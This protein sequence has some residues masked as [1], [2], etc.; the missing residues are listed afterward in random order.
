MVTAAHDHPVVVAARSLLKEKEDGTLY[1][2]DEG[3]ALMAFGLEKHALDATLPAAIVALY[4]LAAL[5]I[6]KGSQQPALKLLCTI[7][8][9]AHRLPVL[10]ASDEETTRSAF[11]QPVVMAAP[12]HDAEKPEGS[13]SV[14]SFRDPGMQVPLSVRRRR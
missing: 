5:L 3:A 10:T 6:E 12:S 14:A 2:D 7:Q 4:D 13:I 11:G 8:S 1:L 9:V